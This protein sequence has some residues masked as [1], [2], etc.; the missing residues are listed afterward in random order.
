MKGR[1]MA[2]K[3]K[4]TVRLRSALRKVCKNYKSQEKELLMF[5]VCT[6]AV[7]PRELQTDCKKCL[8]NPKSKGLVS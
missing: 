8:I 7:A 2:N 3:R 1:L 6:I 5:K 4:K